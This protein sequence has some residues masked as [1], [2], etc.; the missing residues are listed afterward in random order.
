M[1]VR[2]RP[3][4]FVS[5]SIRGLER[6]REEIRAKLEALNLADAWLFEYHGVASG[7]TA[8][9]QYLQVARDCDM[10]VL[11]VGDEVGQGTRD[12]YDVAFTDNPEKV[13][14][15]LF[16]A[17][18]PDSEALRTD[19]KDRHRF[20][21]L[22]DLDALPAAIAA[23]VRE[24]LVTGAL[25]RPA[26]VRGITSRRT[27][28]R[29][30]LGMPDRF[31]FQMRLVGDDETPVD[32]GALAAPAARFVL[33]GPPGSGKTDAAAGAV[34]DAAAD[35]RLPL[36]VTASGRSPFEFW[37]AEEF[38]SVRF[39]PGHELVDQYLR[40]GRVAV[41][42]DGIDDLEP[43]HRAA[44]LL[45]VGRASRRYPRASVV[46]ISRIPHPGVLA[47]F[48]F[49]S[50][51]ALT[52]P[53]LD[54]LFRAVGDPSSRT[55][56]LDPRLLDLIRLPFWAALVARHGTV[57]AGALDLLDTMVERRLFDGTVDDA[58]GLLRVRSALGALAFAIRPSDSVRLDR[59]L[60]LIAHWLESDPGRVRFSG[61]SADA[62]LEGGRRTG[63]VSMEGSVLRFP[64]PLVAAYLA[65]EHAVS[66][67]LLPDRADED[68]S[69]FVAA[70]TPESEHGLLLDV[71]ERASILTVAAFLRLA[72]VQPRQS[73]ADH[74]LARVDATYRRLAPMIGADASEH[75]SMLATGGYLCVRSIPGPAGPQRVDDGPMSVWADSTNAGRAV[76]TCWRGNPL[77]RVT[78]EQLA[79]GLILNGFKR[80]WE[81]LRP[82]GEPYPPQDARPR[83]VLSDPALPERLMLFVRRGRSTRRRL[84]G[85]IRLSA[86]RFDNTPGEPRIAV[87]VA[88]E[89]A[90]F[91]VEWGNDAPVV[92]I[93]TEGEIYGVSIEW[94]LADPDA[95]AYADLQKDL[96]RGLGSVMF[97][98]AIRKPTPVGWN[99]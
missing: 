5:S 89:S 73:D 58:Q 17:A 57:V 80:A 48:R 38:E 55:D 27:A 79:A 40:D 93:Q 84:L 14:P 42:V 9:R 54:G 31:G 23:A 26:L 16:G 34:S 4:V 98:Q 35:G 51:G 28:R 96:E 33:S 92:D 49:A 45:E 8:D 62:M 47:D 85:E 12:E 46:V 43:E 10:F 11:V 32:V 86:S 82:R 44:A 20:W 94:V 68:V 7:A 6:L 97:S 69:A 63:L 18:G 67:R 87:H 25:V 1:L 30:F 76:A 52:N 53:Q 21:P 22:K 50:V 36:L 95:V 15:F 24:Y 64:H 83:A 29:H 90:W 3:L 70:L 71:L 75:V 2:W 88:Q 39:A 77:D 13:L 78:P 72:R 59:A 66:E 65:A 74:D 61:V 19:I 81:L 99:L 41:A 91:T 60:A 56:L 37:I